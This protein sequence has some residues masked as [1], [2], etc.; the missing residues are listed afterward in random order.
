MTRLLARYEVF[1]QVLDVKGSVVAE[2]QGSQDLLPQ[3]RLRFR[4]L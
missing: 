3:G 2:A 4:S 1:K